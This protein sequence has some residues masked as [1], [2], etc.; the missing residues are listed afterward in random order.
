LDPIS[1]LLQWLGSINV[2]LGIFNLVPGFPLDGGRIVR[3]IIWAVTD[4]LRAATRWASY[5]GQGVAW[6]MIA[7]GLAMVS[8]ISIPFFGSG[9]I[10]GIWLALIGWFLHGAAVSGYQQVVIKDILQDVPV[11]SIMRTDVAV[12]SPRIDIHTLVHEYIMKSDDHSFPVVEAGRL[13]GLITLDDVRNVPREAWRS[14]T[15]AQA[16]TPRDE[17]IVADADENTRDALLKLRQRDIR[18]LPVIRAD[19]MVGLLRR[20]DIIRWLQLQGDAAIG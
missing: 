6:L 15:V 9:L 20:R 8:G 4:D 18:Q 3:S 5:L 10:G 1:S 14:R 13:V 2:M 7:G 12:V 16:M 17:L 11:D 19:E